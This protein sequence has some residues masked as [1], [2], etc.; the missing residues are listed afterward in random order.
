MLQPRGRTTSTPVVVAT[1]FTTSFV[2]DERTLREFVVG[3]HLRRCLLDRGENAALYLV[4]DTCDSLLPRQLRLGVAKDDRLIQKL[5]PFC[6]RPVAEVPDP[7]ECHPSFAEHHCQ[8]LLQRLHAL[9]IHPVVI[10]T[11]LA[12]KAGHYAP[13]IATTFAN[14]EQMREMLSTRF[15]ELAT[16]RLFRPQCPSCLCLDA[17]EIQMLE[18]TEVAFSC[19][20]C[21]IVTRRDVADL[22]GKL[23]WKLDCAARW[24]ILGIDV[25]T[26]S[27]HHMDGLG[28]YEVA[29]FVS[30]TFFGG[31][32]PKPC[33]Y[34][35]VRITREL[36]GRLLETLPPQV[37]KAMLLRHIGRDLD[38]TRAHVEGFCRSHV[39]RTG[40]TFLDY[41]RQD[42]PS[43]ALRTARW[44]TPDVPPPSSTAADSLLDYGLRYTR[45]F[46]GREHGLKAPGARIL[47][48]AADHT[49]DLAR[50]VLGYAIGLRAIEPG[51]AMPPANARTLIKARLLSYGKSPHLYRFLRELLGQTEG[52]HVSSLLATL[53]AA[54]L[55]TIQ[56]LCTR[57]GNEEATHAGSPLVAN[58]Q[59]NLRGVA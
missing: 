57:S 50:D 59:P 30:E 25:E 43:E 58:L 34:G 46:H 20:R 3:D 32:V 26:F 49:L 1:G 42:V 31:R 33:K 47:A 5:T 8:H 36:S 55:A 24:N 54:Y 18:G 4:N 21:S 10:D 29:R 23:G 6:G 37:L 56:L 16:R 35:H 28:T 19:A 27:K 2:G 48:A 38:L 13:Y 44:A 11:Y 41:V 45:F 14:Y 7:W 9:D 12:Y 53:P 17:T 39:I 22:P 52:P 15:P 51:Q 40:R